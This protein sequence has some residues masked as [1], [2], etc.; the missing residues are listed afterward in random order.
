MKQANDLKALLVSIDRKGYP[1]YKETRG[2]Y[3]FEGYQLS[4]DHVQG[5]PFASPSNVSIYIKEKDGGFPEE[6]RKK[7]ETK[8]A[9]EDYILRK[10]AFLLEK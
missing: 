5:D 6:Y 10:F 1:A 2:I 8:I 4:I 9:L 7:K 3:Q